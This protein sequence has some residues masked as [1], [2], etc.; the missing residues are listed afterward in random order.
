MSQSEPP[1]VWPNSKL[2]FSIRSS[3]KLAF[4]VT[5]RMVGPSSSKRNSY[6]M[7]SC[8]LAVSLSP[9]VTVTLAAST[10]GSR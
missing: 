9:S 1:S 3:P 4:L 7:T 10:P 5:P 8:T 2:P 6:V